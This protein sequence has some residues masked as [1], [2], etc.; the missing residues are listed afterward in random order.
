MGG[1]ITVDGAFWLIYLFVALVC[2]LI[3]ASLASNKNRDG[4]GYFILGFLLGIIGVIIAA[5]AAPATPK[6]PKGLRQVSCPRCNAVQ[7][8]PVKDDN[9][10]CWQCKSDVYDDGKRIEVY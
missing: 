10:E 7:N 3:S 2:G 5:G 9:Y 4:M 1:G 8:M 6:A